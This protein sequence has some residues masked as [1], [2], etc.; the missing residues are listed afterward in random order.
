M[1]EKSE[2]GEMAVWSPATGH[3]ASS[4]SPPPMTYAMIQEQQQH[5]SIKGISILTTKTLL[6]HYMKTFLGFEECTV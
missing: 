4:G 3:T 2:S 5:H 6:I 1:T